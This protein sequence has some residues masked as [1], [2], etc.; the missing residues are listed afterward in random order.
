[1]LLS[2]VADLALAAIIILNW[3]VSAVW[4]LGLIVGIN[5]IT[6]GWALVITAIEGRSFTRSHGR[7]AV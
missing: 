6:S 4:A 7:A 1:M 2:G 5:L 3:P